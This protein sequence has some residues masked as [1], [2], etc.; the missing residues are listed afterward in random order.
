[1]PLDAA[2]IR[3][4][5]EKLG[6]TQGEAAERAGMPRPHWVRLETGGRDDPKLSTAE[7]A[8]AALKCRLSSLLASEGEE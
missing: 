3:A 2:K 1:M 6:I 4:R 5:R 8:A 7:R